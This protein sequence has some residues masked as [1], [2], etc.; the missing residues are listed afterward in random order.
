MDTASP[1]TTA[2]TATTP[3]SA[4]ELSDEGALRKLLGFQL[5]MASVGTN[6]AFVHAVGHRVRL[7]QVEFSVLY[8]IKQNPG[9]TPSILAQSLAVTMPA[10]TAWLGKLEGR[11]LILREVNPRDRRSQHLR[12]TAEGAALA[13]QAL[14]HL[15]AAEAELLASL[16][17][18]EQ[19][20]LMEL[21]RKL[22]RPRLPG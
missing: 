3:A 6:G 18:A 15:L 10:I 8:L 2:T 22:R 1:A 5:A 17:E 20:M 7:A 14:S 12:A 21:L 16:S 13:E 4:A 19:A 9:I 11:S